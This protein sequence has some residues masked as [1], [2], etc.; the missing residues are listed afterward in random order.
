[1][2]AEERRLGRRA[3][4]SEAAALVGQ[5]GPNRAAQELKPQDAVC[6]VSER[7]MSRLVI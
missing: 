3:R 6:N 1:M 4:R 5:T 2:A 7:K